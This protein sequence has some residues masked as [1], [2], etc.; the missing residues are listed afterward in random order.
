MSLKVLVVNAAWDPPTGYLASWSQ[1]TLDR[2]KKRVSADIVE[3]KGDQATRDNVERGIAEEKPDM[4][5]FNGHGES[6]RIFGYKNCVLVRMNENAGILAGKKVHALACKA[7]KELGGHIVELGGMSF[8]GYSEDF[9]FWHQNK[10]TSAE[11][12]H[13]MYAAPTLEPAFR[14]IEALLDGE[15]PEEAFRQ[16]Q[17]CY[18]EKLLSLITSPDRTLNTVIAACTSHD[19]KHQVLFENGRPRQCSIFS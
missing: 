10:Q 17:R 5:F 12:I 15:S 8:I 19:L 18:A 1:E 16:S 9:E 4:I 2:V 14:A 7:G 6:D 13:D 3:L 11:H